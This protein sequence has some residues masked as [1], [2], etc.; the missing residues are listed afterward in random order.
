MIT[1]CTPLRLRSNSCAMFGLAIATIVWS[2]NVMATANNIAVRANPFDLAV[3]GG[4][5]GP[6]V[7]DVMR[8]PCVQ[9]SMTRS[10]VAAP[11][12]KVMMTWG[13]DNRLQDPLCAVVAPS[14]NAVRL[15]G[16]TST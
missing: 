7:L 2:M 13:T 15:S 9:V 1:H 4:P 11:R 3:V 14:P 6:G 12:G 5:D 10:F 8:I 16:H